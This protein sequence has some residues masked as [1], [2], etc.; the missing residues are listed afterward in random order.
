VITPAVVGPTTLLRP[1]FP[2]EVAGSQAT[3]AKAFLMRYLS[4]LG[5]VHAQKFGT[6]VESVLLSAGWALGFGHGI[7]KFCVFFFP[8]GGVILGV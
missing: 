7:R 2:A 8:A 6:L 3:V 4:S 5:Q 1:A